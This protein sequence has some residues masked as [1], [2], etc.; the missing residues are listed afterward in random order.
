MVGC[1]R[2]C[3]GKGVQRFR[4]AFVRMFCSRRLIATARTTDPGPHRHEGGPPGPIVMHRG[5]ERFHGIHAGRLLGSKHQRDVRPDQA[6]P[7]NSRSGFP[8]ERQVM[9]GIGTA[10][11]LTF[12]RLVSHPGSR[13]MLEAPDGGQRELPPR[14]A[15]RPQHVIRLGRP[16]RPRRL[17]VGLGSGIARWGGPFGAHYAANRR[18]TVAA[19]DWCP[20]SSGTSPSRSCSWHRA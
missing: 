15:A 13:L 8:V 16:P 17:Y 11:S 5:M 12:D 6:R 14:L 1:R 18:R 7:E 4:I 20:V 10:F 3:A 9:T 19:A 2:G